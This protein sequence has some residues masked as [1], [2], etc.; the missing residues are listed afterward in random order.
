MRRTEADEEHRR[1]DDE[2]HDRYGERQVRAVWGIVRANY[3]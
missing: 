3:R 1:D 2:E